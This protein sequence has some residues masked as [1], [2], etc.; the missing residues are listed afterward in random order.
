MADTDLSLINAAL[1]RTGNSPISAIDG[2]DSVAAIVT[3]QNYEVVVRAELVRSRLKLPT[4]FQQLSLIDEDEMGS[5]PAPWTY[6]YSLPSDLVKLHTI[7]VAGEP[8]PY[9]QMGRVIFCDF[10]SSQEVMVFYSWRIP[11]S[12]FAPEF[13][14][15]VVRRMEAIY[16][17]SI[18]ERYDEAAERDAA[19][20]DQLRFAASSD[21]Q[22]QTP[23]DPVGS[24]VLN[25]R[26]GAVSS[27]LR[28]RRG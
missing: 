14:E 12:W 19:A 5:P 25:A 22:A 4:K 24:P 17:R 27:T 23:R 20:D 26:A 9:V 3:N 6:G 13:A 8:I 7:K 28:A 15:G 11:E 10:D 18:G 2:N 21:S 1:T 16:L